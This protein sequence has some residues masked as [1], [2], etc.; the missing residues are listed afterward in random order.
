MESKLF[1]NIKKC[2]A[3]HKILFKKTIISK[4][5]FISSLHVLKIVAGCH[6]VQIQILVCVLVKGIQV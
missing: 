4:K 5:S 3:K 1:I 2:F 6:S